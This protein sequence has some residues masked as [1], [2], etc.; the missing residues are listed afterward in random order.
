MIHQLLNLTRPL[1]CFDCETTGTDVNVDRIVSFAFE[2]WGPEGLVR[3][4]KSLVNPGIPIPAGASKVHGIYDEDML[5]CQACKKVIEGLG[6]ACSCEK[7][8]R[9]F[10]F[11]QLAPSLAKGFSECDFSGKN[12]RFD[13]RITSAEMARAGVPWS[14]KGARIVDGERLEQLAVPR[15]L[16]DLYAKYVKVPCSSCNGDVTADVD[17]VHCPTCRGT[18]KVSAQLDGA[19]DALIDVRASTKVIVGQL[20]AHASLPRDLDELHAK[21]WPGWL[22]GDGKFRMVDGVPCFGNWGKFAGRPMKDP[23]VGRPGRNGE[24]Y[25]DFISKGTFSPDVKALA[26]AAKL[27]K[28]PEVK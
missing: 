15:T 9:V 21:Q 13:L 14:Y 1:F 10:Y 2:E 3:E 17:R 8:E 12:V 4:W 16:S 5:K 18:G 25:W 11:H 26:S 19:H 6:D 24:S 20:E 7:P 27:G 22:D 23:E 28:Y